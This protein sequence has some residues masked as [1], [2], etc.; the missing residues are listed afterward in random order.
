MENYID[1]YSNRAKFVGFVKHNFKTLKEYL[2]ELVPAGARVLD[3]GCGVGSLGFLDTDPK[4]GIHVDGYD[5]D[6][7]NLIAKYHDRSK[8][9]DVYDIILLCHVLEHCTL[10]ELRDI[11]EWCR[12]RGKQV[13]IVLPNTTNP[14]M[15]IDFY[16]D[17]THVRPYDS[18]D[19]LLLLEGLGFVV[20]KSVRCDIRGFYD[21]GLL[22]L[23]LRFLFNVV[24][25]TSPFYNY[26][27]VCK[28]ISSTSSE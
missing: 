21:P 13:I 12:T 16:M 22:R 5:I 4:T 15:W 6:T 23:A 3:Y 8:I 18:P 27:V 11:M 10:E 1:I 28:P 7:E 19:L 20:E 9:Q 25:G 24:M 2:E 17:I 26:F 14:F